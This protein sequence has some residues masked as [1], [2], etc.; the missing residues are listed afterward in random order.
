MGLGV[1]AAEGVKVGSNQNVNEARTRS[2]QQ[3]EKKTEGRRG[4]H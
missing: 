3:K 1:T 4:K 2:Y